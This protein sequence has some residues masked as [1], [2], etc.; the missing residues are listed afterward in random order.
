MATGAPVIQGVIEGEEPSGLGLI[1]FLLGPVRVYFLPRPGPVYF[2][3]DLAP[4]TKLRTFECQ[5]GM[6]DCNARLHCQ[7]TSPD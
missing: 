5:S 3:R 7:I 4:F 1:Y 6:P 2:L